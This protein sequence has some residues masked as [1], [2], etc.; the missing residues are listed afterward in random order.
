MRRSLLSTVF[1]DR[2]ATLPLKKRVREFEGRK[3]GEFFDMRMTGSLSNLLTF[4][5]SHLLHSCISRN[6]IKIRF[7][8]S[9]LICCLLGALGGCAHKE[10]SVISEADMPPPAALYERLTSDPAPG[11]TLVGILYVIA[12]RPGERYTFKIATAA[13]KPDCLRLEDLS[14]I[15]LPDF[16]L[17][18]NGTEIR[19]LLPHSGEF[20][21]GTDSSQRL[22]RVFP[23]AVK[24]VDLVALLYG[25]PPG[26]P[27]DAKHLKGSL[28][29]NRYRL[30]V[31][32]RGKWVQSLWVDPGTGL[33]TKAEV[34]DANGKTAYRALFSDFA[35]TE[36][37]T[38]PGRIEIE[39]EGLEKIHLS[40]RNTDMELTSR[41]DEPDFF[42]LKPPSGSTPKPLE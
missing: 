12:S 20:L 16:M 13:K 19:M 31:Y 25:Q 40:L 24:P 41:D 33:L 10:L 17:T 29:G 1:N 23:S 7:V 15:G 32:A 30:D 35:Q 39:T 18:V 22:R 4:S 34:A 21:V 5:P 27:P 38:L 9:V 8:A 11:K 26:L 3:V 14:V 28:D 2:D 6:F 36:T 37:L 42:L